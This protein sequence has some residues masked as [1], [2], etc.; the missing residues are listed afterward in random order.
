MSTSGHLTNGP[1]ED[2]GF[3][4]PFE[5]MGDFLGVH[6]GLFWASP[7]MLDWKVVFNVPGSKLPL[8]PYNR[9]WSSTQ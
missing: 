1:F 9:G 7:A 2:E 5:T 6:G 4:V 8:F 3:L